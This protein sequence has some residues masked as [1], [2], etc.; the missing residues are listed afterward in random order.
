MIIIAFAE[1]TSKLLPN[2]FCK[3]LKHCAPIMVKPD[4]IIMLQ[5]IRYK[6][7]EEIHLKMRDIQ[8]LKQHGWKFVYLKHDMPQDIKTYRAKTCVQFTK[9]AAKIQNICIQTPNALYK[10]L[11]ATW[12]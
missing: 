7:I 3:N 11:I 12:G 8:I 9:H 6:K 10:H 4:E 2:I 5:F 1:N